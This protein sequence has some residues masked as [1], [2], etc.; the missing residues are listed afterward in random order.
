[1][2]KEN[3][4]PDILI[5]NLS[6]FFWDKS[7]DDVIATVHMVL[8]M[9]NHLTMVQ[10]NQILSQAFRELNDGLEDDSELGYH[11]DVFGRILQMDKFKKEELKLAIQ[12][13]KSIIEELQRILSFGKE[14]R[15][16]E[17]LLINIE[18]ELKDLLPR[19]VTREKFIDLRLA[20]WEELQLSD[21]TYRKSY[22][23]K[24]DDHEILDDGQVN[25]WKLTNM[26]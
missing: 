26:N 20:E 24:Y 16:S 21:E 11:L 17:V 4:T 1:M 22:V 13:Q 8:L 6:K 10:G 23:S 5:N 18:S 3:T 12:K 19:K 2:T 15:F 25:I 9:N 7:L 14:N